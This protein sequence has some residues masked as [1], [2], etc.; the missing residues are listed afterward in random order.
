MCTHP[1]QVVSGFHSFN[2]VPHHSMHKARV[3]SQHWQHC[4]SKLAFKKERCTN[5]LLSH[6]R[7][8]QTPATYLS[9]VQTSYS[10]EKL[11]RADVWLQQTSAALHLWS[12]CPE[13]HTK[14][15]AMCKDPIPANAPCKSSEVRR[16]LQ[17]WHASK[18]KALGRLTQDHDHGAVPRRT[19]TS[20][21]T[22]CGRITEWL[23]QPSA[24]SSPGQ[25]LKRAHTNHSIV[26]HLPLTYRNPKLCLPYE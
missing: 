17:T 5:N 6:E 26:V 3:T 9:P 10:L 22:S 24:V 4:G 19:E 11:E 13:P 12:S 18:A 1:L 2:L 14:W 23:A 16:H 20:I 15:S 7:M 25:G 21:T 8:L